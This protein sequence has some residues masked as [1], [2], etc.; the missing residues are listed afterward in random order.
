VAGGLA[1]QTSAAGWY[2]GRPVMISRN[3]YDLGLFNGDIGIA[4]LHTDDDGKRALRVAFPDE[5]GGVRWLLPGRLPAHETAFAMTVH[6][7]Q[8]SEFDKLCLLLPE[9]WQSVITRELIYTA[10]TRGKKEFHLFSGQA[11]WQQ[12]IL[13][14]VHRASGLRDALWNTSV[15]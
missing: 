8:G 12:G 3:D 13:A 15:D 7:S 11:C 6:K 5:H 1:G 9:F 2:P 14:R 10:V 4:L